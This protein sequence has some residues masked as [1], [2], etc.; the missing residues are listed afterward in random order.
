LDFARTPSPG[1]YSGRDAEI[2]LETLRDWFSGEKVQP[3]VLRLTLPACPVPDIVLVGGTAM[4]HETMIRYRMLSFAFVTF[5][6][7]HLPTSTWTFNPS[8][9]D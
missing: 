5:G 3:E 2:P 8:S 9:P 4:P 1:L 7:R 6:E